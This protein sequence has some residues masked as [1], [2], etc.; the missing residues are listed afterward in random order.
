MKKQGIKQHSDTYI[1]AMREDPY[2]NALRTT[3]GY[4]VTCHKAKGG[5]MMCIWT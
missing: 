1:N 3:F 4:V 2:L 5:G